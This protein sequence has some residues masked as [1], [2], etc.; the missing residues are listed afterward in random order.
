MIAKLI[1]GD[2]E[3]PRD[4]FGWITGAELVKGDQK[5]FLGE[6]IGVV[7]MRQPGREVTPHEQ[8]ILAD[9]ET[10]LV[11]L[12]ALDRREKLFDR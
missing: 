6:V 8:A 12:A 5:N 7:L 3:K 10:E 2:A 1:A 9:D 4:E 11:G